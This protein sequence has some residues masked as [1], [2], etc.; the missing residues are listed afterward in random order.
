M[1]EIRASAPG[2]LSTT[3]AS[4]VTV[5]GLDPDRLRVM[6]VHRVHALCPVLSWRPAAGREVRSPVHGRAW[7]LPETHDNGAADDSSTARPRCRE[8]QG[9]PRRRAGTPEPAADPAREDGDILY[10]DHRSTDDLRSKYATHDSVVGE[11]AQ[12]LVDVDL[13]L[14]H[15]SLAEA[16]GPPRRS[17]TSS[18]ATSS[19]IF[20]THRLVERPRRRAARRRVIFLAVPDK[21]FT[22]DFRRQTSRTADLIGHH[23]AGATVASPTQVFDYVP[24]RQR[25]GPHR[26]ERHAARSE[27]DLRGAA[28]PRPRRGEPHRRARPLLRT[29]LHGLHAVSFLDVFREVIELGL[30]PSRSPA[31]IPP[32][33]TRSS[34]SSPCANAPPR[35]R[36]SAP[37]NAA[38]RSAPSPRPPGIPVRGIGRRLALALRML[39]KA[40]STRLRTADTA[41]PSEQD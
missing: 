35:A 37:R 17:I 33:R 29:P 30:I 25:G 32:R 28:V 36:P 41:E 15:Q 38:P 20:P 39:L 18:P 21:R 7:T 27:A 13:V 2:S 4:G 14:E 31:S 16:L 8:P 10:A 12:P 11:G 22:F 24:R 6:G 5:D 19:S 26:L 3:T 40:A 1:P 9:T 23:V 34:S